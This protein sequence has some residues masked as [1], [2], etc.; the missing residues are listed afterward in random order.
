MLCFVYDCWTVVWH[1]SSQLGLKLSCNYF[2]LSSPMCTFRFT[3]IN[4]HPSPHTSLLPSCWLLWLHWVH[5]CW[6]FLLL[7]SILISFPTFI[8]TP[9]RFFKSFSCFWWHG[10]IISTWNLTKSEWS[11]MPPMSQWV[12]MYFVNVSTTAHCVRS[13]ITPPDTCS[14]SRLVS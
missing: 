7:S 1:S 13:N 5:L 8:H 12:L 3:F 11:R 4:C 10:T 2:F 9:L 6:H 14:W